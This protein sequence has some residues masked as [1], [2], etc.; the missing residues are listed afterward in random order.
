[1]C[2][3]F[4]GSGFFVK[5]V[6]S[7]LTARFRFNPSDLGGKKPGFFRPAGELRLA[8][9]QISEGFLLLRKKF[10]LYLP[11]CSIHSPGL[12]GKEVSCKV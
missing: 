1:M 4:L 2:F 12:F 7:A 11:G 10:G 8:S 3:S 6:E 5:I 9:S